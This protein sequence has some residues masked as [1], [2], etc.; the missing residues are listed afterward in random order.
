MFVVEGRLFLRGVTHE[1]HPRCRPLS[2]NRVDS[3]IIALLE[4]PSPPATVNEQ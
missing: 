2:V 3:A 1:R 4:E